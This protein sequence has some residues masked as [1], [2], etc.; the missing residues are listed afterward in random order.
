MSKL[1]QIVSIQDLITRW[2]SLGYRRLSNGVELLGA[3][4]V[5]NRK[6]GCTW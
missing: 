5:S 6:R 3:I 2:R 1:N 4:P